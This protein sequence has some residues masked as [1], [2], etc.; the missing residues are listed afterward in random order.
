[1]STRILLFVAPLF[2]SAP[3]DAARKSV[4]VETNCEANVKLVW[5]ALPTAVALSVALWLH[6]ARLA[7]PTLSAFVAEPPPNIAVSITVG[8]T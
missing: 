2:G 5:F 1:M 8:V 7:D 3:P 6:E 4:V